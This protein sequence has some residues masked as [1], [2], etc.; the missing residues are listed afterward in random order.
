L[1]KKYLKAPSALY[2]FCG[3]PAMTR[4]VLTSL[5]EAFGVKARDVK[6]ERFFF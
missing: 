2:Y 1:L 3:P 6:R 5:K 4:A